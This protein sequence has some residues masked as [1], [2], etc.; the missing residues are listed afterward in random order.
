MT[1]REAFEDWVRANRKDLC[2]Q[3]MYDEAGQYHYDGY[4]WGETADAYR[5]WQAAQAADPEI[6]TLRK[7]LA[8]QVELVEKCMAAMNSNA[9]AG[10]AAEAA[11][12]AL[13]E[14][15][16]T[17]KPVGYVIKNPNGSI[18]LTTLSE[19]ERMEDWQRKHYVPAYLLGVKRLES[20]HEDY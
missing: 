8:E 3:Y 13:R 7:Q 10:Q 17:S 15:I 18:S 2:L 19:Y 9:D 14:Q 4:I 16:A 1:Q 12:S 11:L 5:I 20:T 6:A